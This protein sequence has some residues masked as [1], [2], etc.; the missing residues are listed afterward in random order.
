MRTRKQ[1]YLKIKFSIESKGV[2]VSELTK[3]SEREQ[4]ESKTT[5]NCVNRTVEI[6]KDRGINNN[7]NKRGWIKNELNSL[8]LNV[9]L[10]RGKFQTLSRNR[11]SVRF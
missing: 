7:Q 11:A 4:K 5:E 1:F 3:R 2:N 6:N 8:H 10:G 9:R